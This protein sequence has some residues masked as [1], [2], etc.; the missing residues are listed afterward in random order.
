MSSNMSILDALKSVQGTEL[1]IKVK[2]V[3]GR[4]FSVYIV[5]IEDDRILTMKAY[6]R[7]PEFNGFIHD[8]VEVDIPEEK[9]FYKERKVK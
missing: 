3:D 2:L 1:K 6:W 5:D 8:I 9:Q 7:N 4:V